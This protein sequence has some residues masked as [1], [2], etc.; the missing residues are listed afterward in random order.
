MSSQTPKYI[1]R[2]I[3]LVAI[4]V[5]VLNHVYLGGYITPYIYIMFVMLLPFDIKGWALLLWAFAL[6]LTVDMFSDSAGMHAAATLW[7]AFIRPGLIRM[8]SV[9]TDFEPGTEP[10]INTLGGASLFFY[11]SIMV[12]AHHVFLFF[13]EAFR[14][15]QL[16]QILS[17]TLLS[18]LVSVL[19]IFV[20][21]L[22]METGRKTRK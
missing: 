16:P 10:G 15:D 5:L 20:G 17:L 7:I 2:F 3:I 21:F 11:T 19:I 14:I 4:Q 18:G 12:A 1:L 8:V 9:K 6:G 13:V 22:W